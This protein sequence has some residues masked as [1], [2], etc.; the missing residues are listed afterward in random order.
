[1][2][3]KNKI[4]TILGIFLLFASVFAG[5]LLLKNNQI[6]KIGAT[7][8]IPKDVRI[9][10][11]SDLS[12]T[13]SWV[14]D[15]ESTS[16]ISYGTTQNTGSV[17]DE[18]EDDQKFL[19]HSITITGLKPQTNYY[20]KINSNGTIFENNG[21]PWQ[22]TT[23]KSLST[24]MA[25]VPVSGSVITASGEPLKRAL[26]YITINGYLASTLTSESG[27][28]ILQLGSARTPDLSSY[29][30]I[31]LGKTLLEV[32]A[33]TG[34][35]EMATAKV[36][37]KSANPIPALIIGKDQDFRNLEPS[38]DSKNPNADLDLPEAATKESRFNLDGS[39]ASAP[40]DKNVTLESVTEGE[41]VGSTKPEF[42]GDGPAGEKITIT[43]HSDTEIAGTATVNSNGSWNWSPPTNLSEGIHTITVSWI[44]ALGITRTL[45]R[46]FI[47]QAGELPSFVATPS[48]TPTKSPTPTATP[49]ASPIA[50]P[51]PTKSPTPKA[52]ATPK[53][54]VEALPQSGSLTPTI[55]LFIMGVGVIGFGFLVWKRADTS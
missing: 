45:T 4:P 50:T 48:A 40:K 9:S 10:N 31:D 20:F 54:T 43:V 3:K 28:F 14:T 39:Q 26:V 33:K 46:K 53:E 6:F 19:T 30:Q 37:P 52:T 41:V 2:I 42:F 8:G 34:S 18:T 55:V 51:T 17:A 22:F 16:F 47:V 1:M 23:G 5:V 25:T 15:E 44:D 36:F 29:A 27:N 13:I 21:V 24:K 11:L 38:T 49:K 7:S 35:D 12:A 32:S